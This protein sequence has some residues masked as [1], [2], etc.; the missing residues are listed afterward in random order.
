MLKKR[1]VK[2]IA[3]MIIA[4]LASI[5]LVA[6]DPTAYDGKYEYND[7]SYIEVKDGQFSF[8]NLYVNGIYIDGVHVGDLYLPSGTGTYDAEEISTGVY[9][10]TAAVT[11]PEGSKLTVTARLYDNNGKP[12]ISCSGRRYNKV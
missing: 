7:N 11:T 5:A 8:E 10:I 4:I 12:Y 9:K 2:I 6:C 1:G 3:I